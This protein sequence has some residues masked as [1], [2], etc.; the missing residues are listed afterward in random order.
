MSKQ[1]QERRWTCMCGHK[2]TIL[3]CKCGRR[4]ETVGNGWRYTNR[5]PITTKPRP[6]PPSEDKP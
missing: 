2:N 3:Q 1:K 5:D 4:I 6:T